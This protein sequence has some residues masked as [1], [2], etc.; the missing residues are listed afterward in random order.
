MTVTGYPDWQRVMDWEDAPTI[1]EDVPWDGATRTWGRFQADRWLGL[2]VELATTPPVPCR[3]IITWYNA[4][5]GGQQISE[6]HVNIG[7]HIQAFSFT[8]HLGPWCRIAFYQSAPSV[9][10]IRVYAA[11][12]NRPQTA[13]RL[14][15]DGQ[16]LNVDHVTVAGGATRI[17]ESPRLFSG[18][19][20]V[21]FDTGAVAHELR[22]E[23]GD[24]LGNWF[25]LW[26]IRA[27]NPQRLIETMY[28]PPMRFRSVFVNQDAGNAALRLHVTPAYFG[29]G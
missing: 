14:I 11:Q 2:H 12:T 22:L 7:S 5:V 24:Y 23:A 9:G 28:I 27:S 25:R 18:W 20:H 4:Q 13:F 3:F 17:D 19:A 8:P 29:P 15:G 6:R 21:A 10:S 26:D 16:L 1:D